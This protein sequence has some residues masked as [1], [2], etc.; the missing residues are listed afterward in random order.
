MDQPWLRQSKTVCGRGSIVVILPIVHHGGYTA[1]TPDGHRFPM[2]KFA[3]LSEVLIEDGLVL[4]GF[5]TPEP[6]GRDQLFLAHTRAYTDGVL[7]GSL[8]P[9]EVRKIGFPL[10]PSVILRAQLATGGTLMAARL[11]L[12]YGLACNS[13]GGSHHAYADHGAGFCVFNDVAV[14]AACLLAEME[15]L[16]IMVVDLDVHHGDGTAA[17]FASEPRV[18]T[19]SM[20]CDENWPLVKPPSDHDEAVPIGTGDA[21]YLAILGQ[22]LPSLLDGFA[23][24]LVFYIAGVDPHM[25]DR[26]GKLSLSDAGL[27]ARERFVI[28]QV[29]SRAIR[30]VTLLGGGYSNDIDTLANRHALVFHACADYLSTRR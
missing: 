17:I 22:T 18:F 5:H 15:H 13:A 3:R 6:I 2:R 27:M 16:K 30:L 20:H 28:E 25:D 14:A 12:A 4:H 21:G 1:D 24:D 8:M 7:N 9:T 26:L 11:A 10:T 23:P 29:R 19:F